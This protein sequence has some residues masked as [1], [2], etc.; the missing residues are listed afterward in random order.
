[1]RAI[2]M[3]R[4]AAFVIGVVITALGILV[5]G[6]GFAKL[7]E[8]DNIVYGLARDDAV[9]V[10]LKVQGEP[11]A[12]YTMG[13][14]PNAGD[15]YVLRVPMDALEPPVPGTAR[16]GT[17]A[18][19][20]LNDQQAGYVTL[21]ERGAIQRFDLN[22][23]NEDGD[24]LPDE[25]EWQYINADPNDSIVGLEDIVPGEDLDGDGESNWEE[26]QYGSSPIDPMSARRGDMDGDKNI[27]LLDA[28]IALKVL[29]GIDPGVVNLSTGGDVNG[30]ERIGAEEALFISQKVSEDR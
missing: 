2:I 11:I 3:N 1:M 28:I 23:T 21:G 18:T 10:S 15:F 7:P 9:T 30:D 5:T 17:L 14:N 4:K 8:P 22:F 20:F 29:C 27:T 13:E 24:D 12:S 25:W 26:Y 19:L 16:P 6:E